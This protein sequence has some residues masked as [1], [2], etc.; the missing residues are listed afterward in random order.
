M[1]RKVRQS[2]NT[3]V[4]PVG[5]LYSCILNGPNQLTLYST[6][7][8]RSRHQ[9]RS[10]SS[11][12]RLPL[13]VCPLPLLPR[14]LLQKALGSNPRKPRRTSISRSD[15]NG[16]P[17]IRLFRFLCSRGNLFPLCRGRI[18]EPGDIE[19]EYTWFCEYDA[20]ATVR[21]CCCYYSLECADSFLG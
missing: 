21:C 13:L 20:Q 6:R 14:N 9:C 5:W 1:S 19:F 2:P 4:F 16:T 17:R 12:I 7:S 11:K 10:R 15:I 8:Q 18:L 3:Q